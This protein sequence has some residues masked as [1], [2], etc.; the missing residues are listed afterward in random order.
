MDARVVSIL[1]SSLALL[2][3]CERREEVATDPGSAAI[4]P[5]G[6][7]L[8]AVGPD[9]YRPTA[10]GS[11]DVYRAPAEGAVLVYQVEAP[12]GAPESSI[13]RLDTIL[14]ADGVRISVD[15]STVMEGTVLEQFRQESIAG[16]LP[17]SGAGRRWSYRGLDETALAQLSPGQRLEMIGVETAELQGEESTV[18]GPVVVTFVGCAIAGARIPAVAGETVRIY[19]L[20]RFWQT[21]QGV[22]RGEY[23]IVISSRLGWRVMDRDGSAIGVV[24]TER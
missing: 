13:E 22:S 2:C 23:E 17:V 1:I 20:Q 15:V 6:V 4:D 10:C 14:G 19:R 3:A 16:V 9:Y 8:G 12:D 24:V 11:D 7:R 5:P 18:E 21:T